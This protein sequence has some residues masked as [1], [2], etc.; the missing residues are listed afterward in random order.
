MKLCQFSVPKDG[1]RVGVVDGD[2]VI[3]ITSRAERVTSM[4][5][6][7]AQGKTAA[8][9]ERRAR[10]LARGKKPRFALTG[11]D[12]APSARRPHLLAPLD[13]PEV[14]GAGITYRRSADYYTAHQGR[15]KGIYDHVY[16]SERPE[17]FLKA[18]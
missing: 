4:L 17:L 16:E 18:T 1:T 11:L 14:W 2:G 15:A 13:P 3:D 5:D 6:L 7:I 10:G 12:T 9:V 8:G